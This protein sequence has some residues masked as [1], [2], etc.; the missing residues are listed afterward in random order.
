RVLQRRPL[1]GVRRA[2]LAGVAEALAKNQ[3]LGSVL[4][5]VLAACLDMAGISKGALYLYAHEPRLVLEHQ[6]GFS[7]PERPGLRAAF[8]HG[9]LLAD[10]AER[11]TVVLIPSSS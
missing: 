4:G 5:D 2:V 10:L 11:G 6:T 9:P 7:R 1:Q 3:T 8:A